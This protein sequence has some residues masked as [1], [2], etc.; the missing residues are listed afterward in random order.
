MQTMCE[1]TDGFKISE[2]D[3][4]L[5]GPG[6]IEGTQQSGI[7]NFK[8]ADIV[9]DG[10]VLREARNFALRILEEDP[11]LDQLKNQTLKRHLQQ[12]KKTHGFGR[13]S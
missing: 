9:Q 10:E 7:L 11:S 6:N 1:T 5:R 3:L 13:I 12:T 2:A 4:K 8:L